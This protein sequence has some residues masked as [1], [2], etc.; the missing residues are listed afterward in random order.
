MSW[1]DYD[2]SVVTLSQLDLDAQA[3]RSRWFA[4]I[5]EGLDG[6]GSLGLL[7]D[8]A[9]EI[10]LDS[11][12]FVEVKDA[13]YDEGRCEGLRDGLE[14]LIVLRSRVED[15]MRFKDIPEEVAA[16]LIHDIDELYDEL[17]AQK[18]RLTPKPD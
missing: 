12:D 1:L 11:D 6:R 8:I 17:E 18:E 3:E 2:V 4:T 16:E 5:A 15:D 7:H 10:T 14:Q 13:A 9:I